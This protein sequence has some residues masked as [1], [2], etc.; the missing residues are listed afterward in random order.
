MMYLTNFRYSGRWVGTVNT[1]DLSI[2]VKKPNYSIT[3]EASV[4]LRKQ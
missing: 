1:A 4:T 3:Q 2:L